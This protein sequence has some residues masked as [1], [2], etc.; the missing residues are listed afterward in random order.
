MKLNTCLTVVQNP[1]YVEQ[2]Q[3]WKNKKKRTE[4]KKY[5]GVSN[6][7]EGWTLGNGQEDQLCSAQKLW[8]KLST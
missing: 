7:I 1:T 8:K 4:E 2:L 6:L 5:T 3:R